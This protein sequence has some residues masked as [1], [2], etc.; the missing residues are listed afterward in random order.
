[1]SFLIPKEESPKG[2]ENIAMKMKILI[3]I[4]HPRASKLILLNLCKLL[5]HQL[6]SFPDLKVLH[7]AVELYLAFIFA[8]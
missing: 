1:M 6:K 4:P 2:K 8:L 7:L 3:H 5:L